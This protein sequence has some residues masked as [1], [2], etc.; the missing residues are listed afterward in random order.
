M[1]VAPIVYNR[2]IRRYRYYDATLVKNSPLS[3]HAL[4]IYV[5]RICVRNMFKKY[6]VVIIILYYYLNDYHFLS[7]IYGT[8]SG[9]L[10]S[11]LI[12][13]SEFNK[14]TL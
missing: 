10:P 8:F 5:R 6:H 4:P 11:Y 7:K 3:E 1:F 12:Y 13:T 14:F 9:H 2:G